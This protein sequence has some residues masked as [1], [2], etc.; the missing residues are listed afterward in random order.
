[1]VQHDVSTIFGPKEVT[2]M[3]EHSLIISQDAGMYSRSELRNVWNDIPV[4][5]ASKPAPGKFLKNPIVYSALQQTT[6][7]LR[8]YALQTKIFDDKMISPGY[9]KD[10][11]M[12]TFGPVAY[13]LE[14]CGIYFSVFL[15]SPL[16]LK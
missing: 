12:D 3:A 13:V 4:K 10:S 16:I 7:G 9:F 5:A 2:L 8:Y 15:G 1:M 11:F 6:G 14:H